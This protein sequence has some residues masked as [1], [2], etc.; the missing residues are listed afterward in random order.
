MGLQHRK[1]EKEMTNKTNGHRELMRND[2]IK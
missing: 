2:I 1:Y